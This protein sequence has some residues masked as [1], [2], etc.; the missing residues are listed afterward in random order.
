MS[1]MT[2]EIKARLTVINTGYLASNANY[3]AS[4]GFMTNIGKRGLTLI[5]SIDLFE[6]TF[7]TKIVKKRDTYSFVTLPKMPDGVQAVESLYIP[8]PPSF[9]GK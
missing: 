9:F 7:K 4:L 5:G 6:K 3:L 8:T 1:K 2:K